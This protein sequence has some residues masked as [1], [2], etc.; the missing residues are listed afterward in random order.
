MKFKMRNSKFKTP[1]SFLICLSVAFSFS[2]C[3]EK[4]LMGVAVAMNISTD[5]KRELRAKGFLSAADDRA[6]SAA[7]LEITQA[8]LFVTDAAECF[9]KF[10]PEIKAE[11]LNKLDYALVYSEALKNSSFAKSNSRWSK[12]IKAIHI[13]LKGLHFYLSLL[14]ARDVLNNSE[15]GKIKN[16]REWCKRA[17]VKLHQAQRKL[18]EDL[19]Q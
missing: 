13:G 15:A 7:M 1:L 16:L 12:T 8:T 17:S 9:E 6:A 19:N 2:A 10:T 18:F 11:L 3:G 4:P 5:I 14:P